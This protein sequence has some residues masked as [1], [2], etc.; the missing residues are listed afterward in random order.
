MPPY[1][2][3][4]YKFPALSNTKPAAGELPS[5]PSLKL[6]S[7][8]SVH[9]PSPFGESSNTVPAGVVPPLMV[10]PYRFPALSKISPAKGPLPSLPSKLIIVVSVTAQPVVE[11]SAKAN[12]AKILLRENKLC[13][14]I[15]ASSAHRGL[16]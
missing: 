15:S 16:K 3:V 10:V 9:V 13:S 14:R 2:V 11:H 4:P 7:T 1:R 12:A 5:R 8:D 6:Y